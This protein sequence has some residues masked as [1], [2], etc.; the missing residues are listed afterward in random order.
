MFDNCKFLKVHKRV[1]KNLYNV[2]YIYICYII[3]LYKDILYDLLEWFVPT[4]WLVARSV[5]QL[6]LAASAVCFVRL[7]VW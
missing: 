6:L 1:N 2:T 4:I 7:D 5:T 3:I